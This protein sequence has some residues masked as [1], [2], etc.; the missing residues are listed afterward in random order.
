MYVRPTEAA[1]VQ[2]DRK[3][4][5][6]VRTVDQKALEKLRIEMAKKEDN[7]RN[8]LIKKRNLPMSLL[9]DPVKENKIRLLD[10][11]TYEETFGPKSRRKK[12]K[13]Q[14]NSLEEMAEKVV[15]KTQTYEPEKDRD[16]KRE[17][18][19]EKDEN[20]DKRMAAG[21][22]KRI[23]EELYKVLDSS[24][25]LVQ[26]LD[27]RD[28]EG[29]R[30]KVLEEHIKKNCPHKHLVILLNKCDLVP[31]WVTAKWAKY[32]S[33][34]YPTIAYR[35]SISNPFGKGALINLFRQFDNFHKDKKSISIGFIGY[36]NVGKSSV[37]NSL[38][39]KKVCKA[40]P[41]PGETKVWQYIALTKRIYLIDCPGVVHVAE[42]KSDINSVLRGCV[43]AERIDDPC[44]Y[45][46]EILNKVRPEHIKRIYGV[47]KWE[48]EE[49]FLKQL[50]IK[51]GKLRKGGEPDS[52]A[53][54]KIILM[55]WQRGEIPFYNLPPGAV[56]KYS[57]HQ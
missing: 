9:S 43:R 28:P 23:W 24:D 49:D 18:L 32:L 33:K 31:V 6:N 8:I 47:E 51:K 3:W 20:R 1:R 10:V 55:D 53:T 17:E 12:I 30:S 29:T 54:A 34:D 2:P 46:P 57:L 19:D 16:I 50:A 13:L 4:F 39:E 56:D 44:Y 5:G 26:I 40:A 25:V 48:D 36:P 14:V 38:K 45:I 22:S 15:E 42:G 37:I 52:V 7:P 35:A 11:E 27:A 41:I 21:Q